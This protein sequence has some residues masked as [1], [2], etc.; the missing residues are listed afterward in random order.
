MW[1]R[2]LSRAWAITVGLVAL[3][4][5]G[6]GARALVSDN[7]I[8]NGEMVAVAKWVAANTP[9]GALVA[10][11]DIGALGY[12]AEV[13]LIDLAGL[14]SPE[15]IPFIRDQAQI[16]SF[17][18]ERRAEYFINYPGWCPAFTREM[19]PVFQTGDLCDPAEPNLHMTV[20]QLS[21]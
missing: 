13:Q 14:V 9:K 16:E 19:R 20:Y 15:V 12:F 1:R 5:W 8:I 7:G 6:I 21:R 3:A 10:A 18:R 4:F 17:I 2:V 11:H